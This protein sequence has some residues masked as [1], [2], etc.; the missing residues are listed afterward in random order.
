VAHAY[1]PSY[2]GAEIR[3]LR[4]KASLGRP[5]LE[6]KNHKKELVEIRNINIYALNISEPN[7][8]F[9]HFFPFGTGV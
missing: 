1:N 2:S 4:F 3:G 8:F 5:Y 7:F 9:F 6:K